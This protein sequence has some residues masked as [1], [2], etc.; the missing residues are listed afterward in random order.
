MK[1]TNVA[2]RL[3]AIYMKSQLRFRVFLN[4]NEWCITQRGHLNAVMAVAEPQLA[5][6]K[7][8]YIMQWAT[9]AGHSKSRMRGEKTHAAHSRMK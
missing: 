3:V 2:E 4:K 5:I 1:K 7:I 8:L 6:Y 9:S